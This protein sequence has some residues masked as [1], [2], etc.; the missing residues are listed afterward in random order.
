MNSD[1]LTGNNLVKLIIGVFVAILVVALVLAP[2]IEDASRENTS[3]ANAYAL[4]MTEIGN[5]TLT[6]SV[7]EEEH[8]LVNGEYLQLTNSQGTIQS[9]MYVVTENAVIV[10]FG[11]VWYYYFVSEG[12]YHGFSAGAAILKLSSITFENGT[13]TLTHSG[14]TYT[15]PYNKVYYPDSDGEYAYT[16]TTNGVFVNPNAGV[17]AFN[18]GANNNGVYIGTVTEMTRMFHTT[19]GTLDDTEASLTVADAEKGFSTVKEIVSSTPPLLIVPLEYN[20]LVEASG[21]VYSLYQALIVVVVASLILVVV[22]EIAG[23]R[24]D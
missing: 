1:S 9:E 20:Y 8:P 15:F 10:T 12:V 3:E 11:G 21:G 24:N 18:G 17:I 4:R 5:G 14:A 16:K 13:A 23:R 19:S 22:R 2:V 6:L 7:D